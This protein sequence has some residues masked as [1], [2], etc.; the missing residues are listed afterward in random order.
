MQ[1]KNLSKQEKAMIAFVL[2]LMLAIGLSWSRISKGIKKG[3]EPY[4]KDKPAVIK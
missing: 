3:F 1:L 2:I 4:Y